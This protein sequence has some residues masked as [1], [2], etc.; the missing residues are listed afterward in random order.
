LNQL[1]GDF[2]VACADEAH[3]KDTPRELTDY[4]SFGIRITLPDTIDQISQ[5]R[6]VE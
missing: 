4:L 6:G 1:A 3:H 5:D 2:P